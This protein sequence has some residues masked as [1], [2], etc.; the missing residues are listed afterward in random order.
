MDDV[1]AVIAAAVVIK[2]EEKEEEREEVKALN[3]PDDGWIDDR[4]VVIVGSI[5]LLLLLLVV[6]LEDD[7]E[8]LAVRTGSVF[9][10]YIL[11]TQSCSVARP[12]CDRIV[13]NAQSSF[14]VW[15]GMHRQK[16]LGR[17]G[18]LVLE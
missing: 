10:P 9:V 7:G 6:E 16:E 4:V 3:G 12:K 17:E 13:G 15:E 5:R 2:E 8:D 14:H 1:L 11:R 18:H